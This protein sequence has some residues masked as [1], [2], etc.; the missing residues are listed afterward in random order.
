MYHILHNFL[1]KRITPNT[2]KCDLLAILGKEI[3]KLLVL[4]PTFFGCLGFDVPK[5]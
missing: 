3:F 4:P 2:P 1:P 5:S